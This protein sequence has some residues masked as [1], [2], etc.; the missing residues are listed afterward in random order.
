LK[1]VE[2]ARIPVTIT[3]AYPVEVY[4]GSRAVSAEND[5][6]KL[7]LPVGTS[8][9]ISAPKFVLNV[10]LRVEGK[11][12]E[13]QTPPLG[14][15]TVRTNYE[16]CSVMIAKQTLG[17]PPI[18][19]MPIVSGQHRVDMVCPEGTNPPGQFVTIAPNGEAVV[20]IF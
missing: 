9:R 16:T 20:R 7:S 11:Q 1:P 14:Y 17:Y 15:L 8:L 6:H 4:E 13:F 5:S 19:R 2:V 12:V 10:P 18:T 3:S